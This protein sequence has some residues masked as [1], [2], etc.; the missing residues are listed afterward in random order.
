M[1]KQ[2]SFVTTVLITIK[3]F[4]LGLS[5][6]LIVKYGYDVT[7]IYNDDEYLRSIANENLHLIRVKIKRGIGF[8]RIGVIFLEF[9][10]LKNLILFSM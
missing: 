1:R 6:H 9:L 2:I 10:D 7:F 4:L 5:N 8:D 3:A